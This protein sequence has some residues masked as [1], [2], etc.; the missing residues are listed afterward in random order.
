MQ[1]TKVLSWLLGLSVGA[2]F[3]ILFYNYYFRFVFVCFCLCFFFYLCIYL[4]FVTLFELYTYR[5]VLYTCL[6]EEVQ[7][8]IRYEYTENSLGS[9]MNLFG[10]K[11]W[12][13]SSVYIFCLTISPTVSG[14]IID[15]NV[16]FKMRNIYN[17]E[18]EKTKSTWKQNY[19]AQT[20]ARNCVALFCKW[21]RWTVICK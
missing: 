14:L 7:V 20:Q 16:S 5:N 3:F 9:G 11:F 10:L 21:N 15:S 1:T 2:L 12:C 6:A 17:G 8:G 18:R 4:F 13:F 19:D